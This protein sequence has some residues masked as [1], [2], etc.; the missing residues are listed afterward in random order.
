[1]SLGYWNQRFRAQGTAYVARG[2]RRSVYDAQLAQIQP[3]LENRVPRGGRL[4][5]FGCGVGRFAPVLADIC[6]EYVGT[7]LAFSALMVAPK[8][9]NATY[10]PAWE[11]TFK[12]DEF[13]T[14]VALTVLQHIVDGELFDAWTERIGTGLRA[15]GRL[16]VWDHW[17]AASMDT[18]MNPRGP[19]AIANAVNV[20][21][22]VITDLHDGHWF[23]VA[24]KA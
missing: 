6:D 11:V 14:I 9:S 5:D 18:H 15:G 16:V 22:F 4:L 2:G 17:P 8:L 13:D 20:Q 7:D 1:M 21:P 10:L 24:S 12:P 3:L 23:G 19:E